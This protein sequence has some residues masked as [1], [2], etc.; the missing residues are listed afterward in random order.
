MKNAIQQEEN[1]SP[2][3]ILSTTIYDSVSYGKPLTGGRDATLEWSGEKVRLAL[4]PSGEI[5]FEVEPDKIEKVSDSQRLSMT[6]F[7]N[8]NTYSIYYKSADFSVGTG[9]ALTP[10]ISSGAAVGLTRQRALN[11]PVNKWLDLFRAL[12]VPVNDHTFI[13]PSIGKLLFWIFIP[14]VIIIILIIVGYFIWYASTHQ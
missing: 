2:E 7:I 10:A 13:P 11:S 1:L 5:I 4:E 12:N 8:G 6:F 9:V 3:K 14:I